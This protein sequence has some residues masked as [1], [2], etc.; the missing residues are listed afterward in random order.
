MFES[1]VDRIRAD[2]PALRWDKGFCL[3]VADVYD[4]APTWALDRELARSY[5]ALQRVSLRQFELVVAGGIRVEP[6]RGAG[7]PYRDSAELRG[8]VR[9]TRV[10][11]LHLTADGHGSV[12]GPEDHPMRA[13]SGVEVD[14]VPLCH[15]DVFRVVHDVFGHAAF[16][17][18]FGPRGEFTATYLH[19]RM[20][21]VSARPALFTEQIGQVCWF[22]FGPHLRDRSGV[23]RSPGDEGYVPARNRPYPQQ[24]VFA[25]DRRYLDR[26]GSL[27]TTEETR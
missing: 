12:P 14:G 2:V 1:I 6:W 24:K 5:Q 4:R 22:F 8:Q 26:F 21:P 17:Q 3:E 7:L 19:A 15:N 10:L 23:P 13:D 11:K 18:G 27:F 20:Y 9:R 16:D 25:F